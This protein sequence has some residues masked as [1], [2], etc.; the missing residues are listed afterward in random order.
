MSIFVLR[1]IAAT[2]FIFSIAAIASFLTSVYFLGI[3]PLIYEGLG[4]TVFGFVCGYCG[5]SKIVW[6]ALAGAIIAV[7]LDSTIW[8]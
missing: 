3:S 7:I 5:Y 2:G 1:L 6:C 8:E 4:V